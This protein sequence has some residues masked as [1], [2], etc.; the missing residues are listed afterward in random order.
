MTHSEAALSVVEEWKSKTC[1]FAI[2]SD[3]TLVSLISKGFDV[4]SA[5]HKTSKH[6]NIKRTLESLD[7]EL[8]IY[9]RSENIKDPSFRTLIYGFVES[10]RLT[11]QHL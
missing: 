10:F 5:I 9:L 11:L 3:D 2:Q 8:S 1:E 6:S 4:I 7:I